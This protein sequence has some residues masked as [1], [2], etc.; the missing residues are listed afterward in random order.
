MTSETR[1]NV[2]DDE[3][4]SRSRAGLVR[5]VALLALVAGLTSAVIAV[6]HR[7]HAD[8]EAAV[9]QSLQTPRLEV[10]AET[11]DPQPGYERERRFTGLIAPRRSVDL[12]FQGSGQVTEVLADLGDK[13]TRDQVLA[14]LDIRRNSA[15]LNELQAS[16]AEAQANLTLAVAEEKRQ[17]SLADREVATLRS[18]DQ[19][20]NARRTAEA[21]VQAVSAQ[22]ET[23][24]IE[25]ADSE[26]K[27]PFD[28]VV[29]ERRIE[30]SSIVSAGS[31]AYRLLETGAPEA[32][33][34][35]PL[36]EANQLKPGSEVLV[37][38]GADE[39]AG[40]VRAIVPEVAGGTRT[41][42]VVVALDTDA[43]VTS[44]EAVQLS[45]RDFVAVDG[46]WLPADAL[47]SGVRGLWAVQIV[48]GPA[49]RSEVGRAPVE[50]LHTAGGRSFVRGALQPGDRVITKG[51]HRVSPGQAVSIKMP[52]GA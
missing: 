49:E 32:Q 47:V 10:V 45:I 7:S 46:F 41:A 30:R 16:L 29:A 3:P 14:R 12:G 23:L 38:R 27:A 35:V 34:G 6:I 39:L 22:I 48:T 33:F 9:A 51:T 1:H 43:E 17:D 28:A 21:R 20:V 40:R 44:G 25:L 50:V 19:A 8:R 36:G 26:L 11:V 18:L 37:V 31:L 15:R 4:R 5:T 13:V 52:G 2:A 24:K 42:T